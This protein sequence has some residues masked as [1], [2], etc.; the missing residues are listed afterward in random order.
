M[1]QKK[2]TWPNI[3]SEIDVYCK[4]CVVCQKSNKQGQSRVPMVERPV[5]TEP[6][7]SV[8]M[9]IV[10]PLPL[11]KGKYQYLLTTMCLATRWPDVVPLK[12]ITAKSVADALITVF[13]RTGLPLQ[14]L[15]DNGSQFSGKLM[16]E[17]TSLLGVDLKHTTPYHPECNGAIERMHSTLEGMLRKAHS[18]GKDWVEQLPFALFALRQMPCRSTGFS[19]YELVWG[20]AMRTPLDVIYNGWYTNV[21]RD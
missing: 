11:A 9:D 20:R 18:C 8:A 13:G 14:L 16:K 10:G 5:V 2:L 19:S 17:L 6:Y 4:S 1:I 21:V 12:S 3:S 7:E 15:S